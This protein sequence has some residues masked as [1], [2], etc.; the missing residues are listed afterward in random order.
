MSFFT[1]DSY[2]MTLVLV[3]SYI[4]MTDEWNFFSEDLKYYAY[5]YIV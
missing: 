1:K 3:M 2:D 4:F 5:A